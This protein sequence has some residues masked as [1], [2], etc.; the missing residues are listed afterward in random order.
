MLDRMRVTLIAVDPMTEAEMV[1]EAEGADEVA[2]RAA[3]IAQVPAGWER[4]EH[5]PSRRR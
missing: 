5:P 1:I 2:A 3:A 4:G